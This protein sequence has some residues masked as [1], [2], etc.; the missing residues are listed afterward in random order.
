MP[1]SF[2]L[3]TNTCDASLSPDALD[4]TRL[5]SIELDSTDL[6]GD[7][8]TTKISLKIKKAAGPVAVTVETERGSGGAL[9]SKI[10]TKFVYSGISFDKIQ[11]KA[12]GSHVLESSMKPAPGFKVAFKG[13]K[14]ADLC[15][16]YASGNLA[17]TAVL[18]VKEM[19]KFSGSACIGL[20]SGM[21]L[22]GD[23][24]YGLSG[25]TGVKSFNVGG[26]YSTGG[27]SAAITTASKMSSVNLGLL[28][29]VS[30]ALTVATQS[31]H[32]SS[33]PVD[34]LAVGAA[35][36]APFADLKAKVGSDGVVSASLVKDIAP[37]VTL[38]ASGSVS[39]SDFSNFK[40]GIGL[41]I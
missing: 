35:Y 2:S 28:Y 18:D 23:I 40:Y 27:L 39:A 21:T 6:L 11:L 41:V 14:G 8:F 37:K 9:S 34:I 7:D 13:S 25:S 36:K 26:S 15:V 20:P 3:Q 30:S 22:G 12:D 16:D 5:D 33:K 24:V 32:S 19:S 10:G 17:T 1:N 31:T 4:L 29:T 38:T